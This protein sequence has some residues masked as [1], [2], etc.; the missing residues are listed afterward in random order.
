MKIVTL[1]FE[2]NRNLIYEKRKKN[3]HLSLDSLLAFVNYKDKLSSYKEKAK[4]KL[5]HRL[6]FEMF[7]G[8]KDTVEIFVEKFKDQFHDFKYSSEVNCKFNYYDFKNSV[9]VTEN[10]ELNVEFRFV[11]FE[12]DTKMEEDEHDEGEEEEDEDMDMDD[13]EDEKSMDSYDYESN[14]DS[15]RSSIRNSGDESEY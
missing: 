6:N 8:S 10:F 12:D 4:V 15:E 9:D 3:F 11:Y 5:N 7:Y 13:G 14:A 1:D 2:E